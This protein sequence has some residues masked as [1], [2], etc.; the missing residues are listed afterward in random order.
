MPVTFCNL[1]FHS[2]FFPTFPRNC[3]TVKNLRTPEVNQSGLNVI[4]TI[5]DLQQIL[6]AVCVYI[7]AAKLSATPCVL[8]MKFERLYSEE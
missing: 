5:P 3:A 6:C 4:K 2:E 1:D 7:R 8:Q